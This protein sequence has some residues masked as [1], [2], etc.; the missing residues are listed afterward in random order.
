MNHLQQ[1]SDEELKNELVRR[2]KERHSNF[3]SQLDT[4]TTDDYIAGYECGYTWLAEGRWNFLHPTATYTYPNGRV[5]RGYIPG[6]PTYFNKYD[7][8]RDVEE[9]KN[10]NILNKHRSDRWHQGYVD[11]INTYVRDNNLHYPQIGLNNVE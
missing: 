1:Y 8:Y 4:L 5:L 10:Q 11:G 7:R 9:Y 2:N 6:G 3:I